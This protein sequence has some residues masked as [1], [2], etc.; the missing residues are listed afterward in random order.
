VPCTVGFLFAPTGAEA[1]RKLQ[2]YTTGIDTFYMD[3][4]KVYWLRW[5]GLDESVFSGAA[6]EKAVGVAIVRNGRKVGKVA[7]IFSSG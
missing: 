6:L 4:R 7:G 2:I 1:H 5:D 3:V